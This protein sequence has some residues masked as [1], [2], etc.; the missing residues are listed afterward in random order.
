M[1]NFIICRCYKCDLT[2]LFEWDLEGKSKEQLMAEPDFANY[3]DFTITHENHPGYIVVTR[4]N[5]P[6][7]LNKVIDEIGSFKKI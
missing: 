5:S 4:M 2:N 7:D 3:F 1:K 6:E